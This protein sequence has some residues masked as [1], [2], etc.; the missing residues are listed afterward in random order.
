MGARDEQGATW[1]ILRNG[2]SINHDGHAGKSG[3]D[4]SSFYLSGV[5]QSVGSLFC[6]ALWVGFS[7]LFPDCGE[8]FLIFKTVHPA[9]F[10]CGRL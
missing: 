6:V 9:A 4:E 5:L 3:K 10:R 7:R 1:E 8:P 2:G